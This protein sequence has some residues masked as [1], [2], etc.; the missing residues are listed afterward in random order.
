MRRRRRTPRSRAGKKRGN[1]R[2]GPQPHEPQ[3]G[4]P[5]RGR[6]RGG[7]RRAVRPGGAAR[8]HRPHPGRQNHL[9]HRAGRQPSAR[10]DA[11]LAPPPRAASSPP[12]CSRARPGHP[13]LRLRTPPRGPHRARPHWPEITRDLPPPADAQS[14]QTGWFAGI[15]GPQ[16]SISTSSTIPASGCS[17]CRCSDQEFAEWRAEAIATA[18]RP[19]GKEGEPL[20]QGEREFSDPARP[21]DETAARTLAATF[22]GYLAAARAPRCPRPPGALPH[23][24]RPRGLP[25]PDLRAVPAPGERPPPTRSGAPSTSRFEAYKQVVVQPFFRYDFAR[26]DRQV[27]L[28]DTSAPST[29]DRSRRGS[30]AALAEILACFRHGDDNGRGWR[31][32][33]AAASTASCLRRPRP[34]TCT[35]PITRGSRRSPNRWSGRPRPRPV[36]RRRTRALSLASLR[37]TVE[38]P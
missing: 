33:S 10:P 11:E 15:S 22:T 13:P 18:R 4:A 28:M 31:L 5:H 8:R 3:P 14:T 2:L 7:R 26:L 36:P 17:T 25:R 20:A 12:A 32:S 37:A 1:R 38:R 9:H 21:R 16:P 35:P 19:P 34:T 24:R 23:P 30:R 6:P 27:V 29:T